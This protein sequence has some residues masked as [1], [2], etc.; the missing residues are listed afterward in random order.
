MQPLPQAIT[1][2]LILTVRTHIIHWHG[3]PNVFIT[4]NGMQFVSKQMT[5]LTKNCG[6]VHRTIS[7]Y[8][9]QCNPVKRTN[10]TVKTM[11]AQYVQRNS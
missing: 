6:I 1:G 4:D 10:R 9:P 8:T 11:I 7:T 2:T 5:N 3:Y